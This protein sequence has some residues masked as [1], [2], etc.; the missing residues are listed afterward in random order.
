MVDATKLTPVMIC[1]AASTR[2]L[3]SIV[4]VF[5]PAMPRPTDANPMRF[6]QTVRL[7]R[8][9]LVDSMVLSFSPAGA[10]EGA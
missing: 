10:V 5:T 8:I 7:A 4:P 1:V 2:P 9:F 6:A 3:A